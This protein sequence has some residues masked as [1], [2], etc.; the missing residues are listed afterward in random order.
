MEG[1]KKIKIDNSDSL[2]DIIKKIKKSTTTDGAFYLEAEENNA[3]KNYLNLKIL[4]TK[5]A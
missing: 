1:Y 3:L 2:Y 4:L 5:F